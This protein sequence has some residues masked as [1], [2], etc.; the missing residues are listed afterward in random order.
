MCTQYLSAARECTESEQSPRRSRWCAHAWRSF[1]AAIMRPLIP[2]HLNP[3][4]NPHRSYI[5]LVSDRGN[6]A[7]RYFSFCDDYADRLRVRL[8][9]GWTVD[10]EVGGG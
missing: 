2:T 6:H 9:V 3:N 5:V 4:P 10:G 8:R 7:I 1:I